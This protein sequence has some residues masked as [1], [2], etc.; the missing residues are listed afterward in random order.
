M[1]ALIQPLA[2]ELSYA[3]GIALK[4]K[5][6]KEERKEGRK[7]GRKEGKKERKEGKKERSIA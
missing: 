6:E 7:G 1:A 2:W 3:T 4:S 5:R